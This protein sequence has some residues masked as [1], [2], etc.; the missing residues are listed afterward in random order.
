MF[1]GSS[2]VGM[3][4][5]HIRFIF[6]YFSTRISTFLQHFRS[7][8]LVCVLRF[9]YSTFVESLERKGSLLHRYPPNFLR[10]VLGDAGLGDE[11]LDERSYPL[12]RDGDAHSG[13]CGI[14]GHH[15]RA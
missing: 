4:G 14:D 6:G 13:A 10:Q 2:K 11:P 3:N 15:G 1:S 5:F 7:F 8:F 12:L 9:R